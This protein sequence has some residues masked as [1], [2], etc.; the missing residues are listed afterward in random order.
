[1]F[2][3]SMTSQDTEIS[4]LHSIKETL[5][6]LVIAFILAFVFRAF[7]VEAFVIPTGSMADTL[8]G[9]HFNLTCQ[10]CTHN[11]NFGFNPEQHGFPK[12][13]IPPKPIPVLSKKLRAGDGPICPD[14]G[15]PVNNT[16]PRYVNNGDRILVLK[17][18]Y[19][20]YEPK[21]WDV[22]VFKNPTE[23]RDNFIKRLIGRPEET[24]EIIDGDIFINGNISRKPDY[25]QDILWI[26]CFNFD[27]QPEL[28]R[29]HTNYHGPWPQP[30][31]P[32][33]GSEE[34]WQI[35]Q[36]THQI[37]FNA[38]E[39]P[40]KL[41]FNRQRLL[42]ILTFCFY[43]GTSRANDFTASDMKLSAVLNPLGSNG[44]FIIQL[45]KY[46]RTY[47]GIINF[48]GECLI[49]DDTTGQIRAQKQ[50]TLPTQGKPV[51]ISFANV[52]HHL[53]I[54]VGKLKLS[55]DGPSEPADWDY[56]PDR[57][58]QLFPSV[59]LTGQGDSFTLQHI[60]LYRDVH[61]TNSNGIQY[62]RGTEGNPFTL[63]KDQFFVLGD[64]SPMSHDSRFWEP[65]A[66]DLYR[67]GTVPRD[68]LI[69][70]AFFVYWPSGYRPR[71]NFFP[72]I[73]NV[74]EM[75]LIH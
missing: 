43:N 64:N 10:E 20:F 17:Y 32:D 29:T 68:Y 47:S 18:V 62:R 21:R 58:I 28:P 9:A 13:Y 22:V 59:T 5:E 52:D 19:Q 2:E 12:G 35:D 49:Q 60:R 15:T 41:D 34:S 65:P 61:Y 74:G 38:S 50:F 26:E 6:S 69:G 70:K 51:E 31:H 44:L 75:R 1:M 72:I 23:P 48:N 8:R 63:G 7:I 71:E 33:Q 25:I 46:G 36:K 55:W 73:P 66:N 39:E 56:K 54:Q 16:Y 53:E 3:S 27:Y 11:Y 42:N 24:V 4:A 40:K 57:N 30:F 37:T 14:C 67:A 45:G